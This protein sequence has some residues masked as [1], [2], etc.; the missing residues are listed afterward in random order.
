[1][2][3]I[4]T[5]WSARIVDLLICCQEHLSLFLVISVTIHSFN[6]QIS[7]FLVS[8]ND[9]LTH[10]SPVSHFYTPLK[11]QKT[12]GFLTFSGSIEI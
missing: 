9:F 6:L 5:C 10:F 12:F 7:I 8:G 11:R 1:M 3:L 2:L 4:L